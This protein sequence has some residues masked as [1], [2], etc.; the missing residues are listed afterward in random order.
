MQSGCCI[1]AA[2]GLAIRA[3]SGLWVC[4]ALLPAVPFAAC[5]LL[6]RVQH[7]RPLSAL[8]GP[9]SVH[10]SFLR[11]LHVNRSAYCFS[12]LLPSHHCFLTHCNGR[13]NLQTTPGL[14]LSCRLNE[15]P[16]IFNPIY[17]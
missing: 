14:V 4:L 16:T 8:V 13:F 3:I 17:S 7:Q 1:A 15:A 9:P 10:P 12:S 11:L 6:N 5:L 2:M